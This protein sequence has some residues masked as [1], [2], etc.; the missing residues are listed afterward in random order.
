MP[1]EDEAT[2]PDPALTAAAW[3]RRFQRTG[4]RG[5]LDQAVEWYRA[6]LRRPMGADRRRSCEANLRAGLWLR[7][8]AYDDDHD[9]DELIALSGAAAA[10]EGAAEQD[11]VFL[12]VASGRRFEDL[13]D[14]Q[15]LDRAVGALRRAVDLPLERSDNRAM[16]LDSLG[17]LLDMRYEE[18]GDPGDLAE[19]ERAFRGALSHLP[20]GDAERPTSMDGLARTREHRFGL[21]GDLEALREGLDLRRAAL[22]ESPPGARHRAFVL[23]GLGTALRTWVDV[24][25][26][27]SAVAELL[28]VTRTALAEAPDRADS[29]QRLNALTGLG[30]A[31]RLAAEHGGDTALLR[32]S[33]DLLRAAVRHTPPAGR[34]RVHRLNSLGNA[35]HRL[36]ERTGD[37]ALL[38]EA[39]QALREAV[40]GSG[41]GRSDGFVANLAVALRERY[42]LTGDLAALREAAGLARQAAGSSAA[43]TDLVHLANLGV[44]LQTWYDRTGDVSAAAEAVALAR[45]VLA[46]TAQGSP[47][48]TVRAN[49]LANALSE[50]YAAAGHPNDLEEAISLLTRAADATA[51]GDP[52][53]A[54]LLHNLGKT[55]LTKA[56]ATEDTAVLDQA[57]ST[58]GRAVWAPSGGDAVHANHRMTYASALRT[59]HEVTGDPGVL[60]AAEDAYR[61]VAA[62]E[63]LPAHRRIEAARDWGVAAAD[64][65]R[66]DEALRGHRLAVEL[67]PFSVTR[68]LARSDREH[69]LTRAHGLA[70]DA[71]ACAVNAGA[72]ELA[73]Q[74]LEH[75]RGVLLWQAVSARGEWERLRA[76]HP[77]QAGLFLRLR[78][79]IDALDAEERE[80]PDEE[81]YRLAAE[82]ERLV[83]R[84][85]A[86]PGFADFL[87][88]P[89]LASLL[90]CADRGP[91]VLAY[92]SGY[93]SD[94]LVLRPEGVLVVPLPQVTP[95]TVEHQVT[96]LD[97]A[98]AAAT[99]PAGERQA[100]R[101]LADVLG[102][103]WDH[104]A[105]PVLARLGLLDAPSGD[106]WPRLWWSPG[107]ALAALPLH[108][109]GRPGGHRSVLDRVVS[110]YTPTV[111]TLAY[112]RARAAG[113][114]PPGRLLA[115]A[116]PVT[117][118]A[119]PLGGARREVAELAKLLPF[120]L[121]TGAD[122]TLERVVRALPEHP[123]AH[124]ACHGVSD[125]DDP[126]N[127]RLLVHDHR[128]EPLT[129]RRISR[130]DLPRARLA[131]LSA[132]ETARGAERLADE[133]IHIT[134]AFQVAGY[135]HAIGTLWPVHDAVAV[136]VARSLYRHLRDGREADAPGL[137]TGRSALALHQAVRECR[138]AFPRTPSLWAAHVHSG[139]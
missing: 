89:T 67:L 136:R 69:R 27:E 68:R 82:W 7:W 98:L 35:L 20:P 122:A 22:A 54:D 99:D 49:H 77:E 123:Y 111:R 28:R 18:T 90:A 9:R 94:A 11:L 95:V 74:L 55:L 118:G 139:P 26:D 114:V 4:D 56:Q 13:R 115:V 40:A 100:Q 51:Y 46:R 127:A 117:P 92:C 38:D 50:R 83:T 121:I 134:S 80:R 19:A 33:V 29:P 110:S 93:R 16:A 76:A 97:E 119:R 131:V 61:Q 53:Q 31:L 130:L 2:S 64:A 42:H 109:A 6:A 14:R 102:W 57:V 65:G 72:P 128:R 36:G 124:F 106:D 24:S 116:Q 63:A 47:M 52:G 133:S 3:T 34:A 58:L 21:S 88:A 91:V 135:P 96:R 113:P 30:V 137:D 79:R 70:A 85:R 59:L 71:A 8:R 101:T 48:W 44:V 37:A 43:P 41:P 112:A 25:P 120:D 125:P 62:I 107:G 23:D 81:R 86:L 32:E 17:R 1:Y 126:S 15:D 132:C 78:D 75:G 5:D 105:E 12:G 129:V 103:A 84:I 138:A 66:W 108:A 39:V 45:D 87:A 10:E 60:L 73:V 104:V